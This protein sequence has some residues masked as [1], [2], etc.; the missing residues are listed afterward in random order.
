MKAFLLAAGLGTRLRP[1]TN[2]VPKCMLPIDGQP[3]LYHW[4]QLLRKYNIH[5]VMINLHHLPDA[6]REYAQDFSSS[7]P[8]LQTMLV[9]EETL[10]GS[11]G[12][13]RTNADW[14]EGE[15]QFLIAYADNL[16]NVNLTNL[17]QFHQ[18]RN[19][20]F[21]MGL[22]HTDYPQGCGIATLDDDG[23]V[24]EFVEKPQNPKSNLANAGV[25][26]ASPTLLDY[27]PEG[28]ADLGYHVLPRL[29][30][31]MYGYQLQGYLRDIGTI[32]SYRKVQEEWKRIE[33]F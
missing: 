29:V 19:A 4:F 5:H 9:Y 16:T 11:A 33:A 18:E 7:H 8:D 24:V 32:E 15:E 21:T 23:L 31:K 30:G 26:V 3:M 28:V 14:I 6:V 2:T 25:Y 13:I 17:I 22:F 20:A 27:I 12:T 10:L 1:L